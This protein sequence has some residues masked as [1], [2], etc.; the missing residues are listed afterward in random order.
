MGALKVN[1]VQ[2]KGIGKQVRKR[3]VHNA[4]KNSAQSM[5]QE[6]QQLASL[7]TANAASVKAFLGRWKAIENRLLQLRALLTEMS[8]LRCLSD[9]AACKELLKTMIETLGEARSLARKCTALNYG[10][11]LQTQS[12]LDSLCGQLDLHI[13]DCQLM[14]KNGIMQENPLAICHVTPESSREA[15]RWTIRNLISHLEIGNVGCKQRALDSML[16]IMSDDDKNILMVA[17]QGAV[18][19]LV[20]LLDA[21]QPVIREKSAAAICL[22]ALNDSCEHTVVAEG[23]IAPLVRL[24]DSGSPRAQESAAAGLQGL[25]VSDENAR[26]IT[27]HG[28][29]PALTEV[30]RVGT[31]G[32]QAAAAGTLRN[33]AAVENLRRGISDDGAIPIVINLISSGTSM[34]QENAAATLQNLAVSDDSIRWRII[35]DGAVQPLIRY[36]D[37]SL[38]ICAQEIALGALRNL[39]ACRDNI[40]ALVNAGLLPRLANHLRSGKISMQLVAAATVRLIACSMESRRSLGEA[41]VIGPLVKLLDAKSTMA[42]EY[43]A[44]ALALLLLDEE[45]RKL[46]LAEDWGI[47]GLVLLLDT[48]FKEVGK[49]FPI[50]ALQAL[51]GNAKCRKQM[52]TAGACYHLRQLADKEV[53]GARRLLDRLS[54]SKLR[55][56]I[57]KTLLINSFTS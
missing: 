13:H 39:A 22:L 45:N 12:N 42:Q 33:L 17:S 14:I 15:M 2:E 3:V 48:R 19:V 1:L 20:H 31:S 29:V 37:S 41:G 40:D 32:A 5:F 8:H 10:G 4:D 21:S 56:I 34:A 23:G 52:V 26:A 51:S 43:S 57:S 50:A 46:F 27:A 7:V 9:N 36:L 30:C 16:R 6:A 49:Q 24:L 28:G 25:S 44:Q 38:D 53:T 35:G 54:T 11:K 47:I 55:S 18:T